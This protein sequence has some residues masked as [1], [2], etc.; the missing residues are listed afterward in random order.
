MAGFLSLQVRSTT[1]TSSVGTLNDIPVSFPNKD[2]ITFPTAL[3][4]P[5]DEGIIFPEAALPA[6]QSFPPLHGPSQVI[7]VEVIEWQVVI[8]P[9]TIPHLSW[10]IL[11]RGARQL[12]VQE[13]FERILILGLYCLW[14]TPITNIGVES[15]GGAE[16]ITF[17]APASRCLDD[18]GVV[19]KIPVDSHTKLASA[20]P[21]LISA[22]FL[23]FV[24]LI[25]CP[26]ASNSVLEIF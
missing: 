21:Q 2:G 15:L 7:W 19:R 11:A 1:D 3:A 16:M 23:Q 4:A 8:S 10:M 9:S 5:V 18:L 14:L 13:A 25:L 6:L 12:V 22:G 26:F 24:S 17:W 20:S